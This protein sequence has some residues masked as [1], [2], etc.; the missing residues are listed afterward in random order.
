MKLLLCFLVVALA[1]VSESPK[2]VL[3]GFV[4]YR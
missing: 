1:E 2:L 3:Y 4:S